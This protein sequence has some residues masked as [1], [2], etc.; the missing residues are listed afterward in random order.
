[1]VV[2]GVTLFQTCYTTFY[3]TESIG[4][5][6][7]VVKIRSLGQRELKQALA[8]L[9]DYGQDTKAMQSLRRLQSL[10]L[11]F[12]KINHWLPLSG[13]FLP[14]IFVAQENGQVVSLVWMSPDGK[15]RDC[16]KIDEIVVNPDAPSSLGVTQQ[17][18]QYGLSQLG[19][20][21]VETFLA[22]V[23]NHAQE[24]IAL[25][26]LCGFRRVTARQLW[27]KQLSPEYID[28]LPKIEVKD[29]GL[30]PGYGGSR[31]YLLQLYQDSLPPEV[32]VSLRR[33]AADLHPGFDQQ[34]LSQCRGGFYKS[35]VAVHHTNQYL[36]G[37][38][39]LQSHDYK[40]Y[41][42][43][44]ILSGGIE[45]QALS[46]IQ[47]GLQQ[48][49]L[50]SKHAVVSIQ[51]FEFEKKLVEALENEQFERTALT[52]ILVKDHWMPLHNE[53]EKAKSPILFMGQRSV[54]TTY[55]P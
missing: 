22:Y 44:L 2:L 17:L 10:Y 16:W 53:G 24:A 50:S 40:N 8:L 51:S 21:G 30:M 27:Q 25:F 36:L 31:N 28:A 20:K 9:A 6:I 35:W 52:E 42:L 54:P 34:L 11:P 48:V 46:W 43:H 12:H 39:S 23:D 55:S 37:Y 14:E 38:L 1:M 29:L 49:A 26:K 5:S 3:Q 19:A 4:K 18:V 13:K 32:R 15:T 41:Q 7:I 45:D 47:F 33:D